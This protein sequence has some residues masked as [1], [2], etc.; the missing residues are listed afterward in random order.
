MTAR[1]LQSAART[2]GQAP[3]QGLL[4]RKCE[5]GAHTPGGGAC[6]ACAGAEPAAFGSAGAR[7]PLLQRQEATPEAP[8]KQE[9]RPVSGPPEPESPSQFSQELVDRLEKALLPDTASKIAAGAMAAA[10]VGALAANHEKLPLPVPVPLDWVTPGLS[11]KLGLDG[12]VDAP[13]GIML[14]FK[15][16]PSAP[17][18]SGRPS[19]SEAYR[20]ET[21][22]MAAELERLRPRPAEPA[23]PLSA[24]A[25]AADPVARALRRSA[26]ATT[27]GLQ[28]TLPTWSTKRERKPLLGGELKLEVPG[29]GQIQPQGVQRK[30]D[31]GAGPLLPETAASPG[32]R[33]GALNRTGL[34]DHLKQGLEALSGLDLSAVRVHH[35][36]PKPAQVGAHAFTFGQSIHVAPGQRHQLAHEGWH[37]V[38]QMQSRV[39]ATSRLGG[40]PLN[41]EKVLEQEADFMGAKAE[42]LGAGRRF[43]TMLASATG[44]AEREEAYPAVTGARR[45]SPSKVESPGKPVA[46]AR[47]VLQRAVSFIAGKATSTTNLARHFLAGK[48]DLGSTT[49]VVNGSE[50][51]LIEPDIVGRP[52]ADGTSTV[53][54]DG[55]PTNTASYSM[56]LPSAG[57][58][59]HSAPK[60]SVRALF[61]TL[62]IA[63][64]AACAADGNTKFSIIGK[65]NDVQLVKNVTTH[66]H[67]HATDIKNGFLKVVGPWDKKMEALKSAKTTF[68][69]ATA[70]DAVNK[71]MAAAGGMPADV[72]TALKAEWDR[73][74]AIT[75]G[76]KTVATGG[77]A[78]PS[79][80]IADAACKT[81]SLDAT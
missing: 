69:G 55:V 58:W 45:I 48:L 23:V 70:Q 24:E 29:A 35:D 10:G 79:N 5:C 17:G 66:E 28:L 37:V 47:R 7:R 21:A 6:R 32:G 76:G 25:V 19:A 75:H 1:A 63:A 77:P 4:Q 78:T 40:L 2:L 51:R 43:A 34:P 12:P 41:D 13:T 30:A 68:N 61:K 71:L 57:P 80:P 62:K 73:L 26:P 18:R 60:A 3:S 27:G 81:I 56:I 14:T 46:Q 39:A 53:W 44:E 16:K 36:S 49:T 59:S 8:P 11:L 15:Y 9:P 33:A 38:Q 22:R 74:A 42:A 65:P 52:E 72:A 67:L 20:A 31:A 64:P 54:L 50:N